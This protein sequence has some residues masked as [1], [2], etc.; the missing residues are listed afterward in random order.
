M[1]HTY[2]Q[3]NKTFYKQIFGTP[4]SSP[5]FPI[6]TGIV[7]QDLEHKVIDNLD[8]HLYTYYRY[9]N[10]TFLIIPDNKIDYGLQKFNSY[11]PRLK[12]TH[13]IESN[14]SISFLNFKI[15]KCKDGTILT[16][17]H[18]KDT[19]SGRFIN[20]SSN[21]PIKQKSAIVKN[22]LDLAIL[23]SHYSFHQKIY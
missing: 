18:R 9:V 22:L 13:E 15:I 2:L 11:H 3:F 10:D 1:E 6:L 16:D 14:N 23:L 12:F 19:Y 5:I 17:W 8:F 21:H 4:M 7:M 20:F